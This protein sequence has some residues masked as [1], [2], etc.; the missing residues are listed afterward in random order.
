MAHGGRSYS[1]PTYGSKKILKFQKF[2]CGTRAVAALESISLMHPITITGV[3]IRAITAGSGATSAWSL[4]SGATILST[5]AFATNATAGTV[6]KGTVAETLV[7]A[8]G[9]LIMGS[10]LSTADPNQDCQM[11]VEYVETFVAEDASN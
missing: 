11:S 5:I 2:S 4:T 3:N 9:I 1:D 10:L 6:V 7:P 8:D